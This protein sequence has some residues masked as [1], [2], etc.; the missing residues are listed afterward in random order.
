VSAELKP[1]PFCAS[2]NLSI[3]YRGQPARDFFIG[4]NSCGACGP[5]VPS[6]NPAGG[7]YNPETV[8][9]WNR[10]PTVYQDGE[11][12]ATSSADNQGERG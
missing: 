7:A 3:S 5:A 10:R 12:A 9:S 2:N 11:N 4:C 8:P 6:A 1:C